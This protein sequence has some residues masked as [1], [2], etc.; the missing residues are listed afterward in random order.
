MPT[1]SVWCVPWPFSKRRS[2]VG[3]IWVATATRY[4]NEDE[5][6]ARLAFRMVGAARALGIHV[7]TADSS[8]NPRIG[9]LLADWG[10]EVIRET[11]GAT[12]GA[13]RR[14]AL[15][16]VKDFA[17]PDDA[18]VW[19]EPEKAPLVQFLKEI[20]S[21]LFSGTADIIVPGRSENGLASYPA[22]QA[23]YERCGNANFA[24]LTGHALDVWFGPRAMN[25]AGV[26]EFLTYAG[27]Y[28]D[29]W[30]AMFIPVVRALKHGLRVSSV[31]VEYRH[32]AEQTEAE[33]KDLQL[34]LLKR[35]D[36]LHSL[37]TALYQQAVAFKPLA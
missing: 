22:V 30:D 18:I 33:S 7:V 35:L 16:C 25:R 6:R 32:P 10:A 12:I 14:Q 31:V 37:V 9:E 27:E 34:G 8:T 11:E 29:R 15:A 26:E 21:P 20:C 1:S 28:G 13:G 5:V 19:M 17:A 4:G 36:Q 2:A 24:L 23:A 3:K